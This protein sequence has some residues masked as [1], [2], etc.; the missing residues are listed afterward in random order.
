MELEISFL[1]WGTRLKLQKPFR[2]LDC[3]IVTS[4][5]LNKIK[6]KIQI[7]KGV[8]TD[9]PQVLNI[10]KELTIY[11]NAIDEVSIKLEDLQTY[12]FVRI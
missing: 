10:I 12:G 7:R 8:K 3:A 5:L 2:I 4:L 1:A 9:L 6:T 11:E